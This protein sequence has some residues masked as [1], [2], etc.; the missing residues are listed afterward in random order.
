MF[1][2]LNFWG[3]KKKQTLHDNK[4][5][6]LFNKSIPALSI[7]PNFVFHFSFFT[8]T[9]CHSLLLL[10]WHKFIILK[11]GC[12]GVSERTSEQTNTGLV[13]TNVKHGV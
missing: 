11:L 4:E 6:F 5:T 10:K 12:Q 1:A 2:E 9:P 7:S 3:K 13:F 8:F